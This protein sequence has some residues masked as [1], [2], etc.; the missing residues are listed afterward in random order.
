MVPMNGELVMLGGTDNAGML[1]DHI[2]KYDLQVNHWVPVATALIPEMRTS[3]YLLFN[4]Q[5]LLV[6][7]ETDAVMLQ[8]EVLRSGDAN[9][10]STRSPMNGA[11]P[12]QGHQL[13]NFYGQVLMI[14]GRLN[15]GAPLNVDDKI[16]ASDDGRN[17]TILQNNV[18]FGPRYDFA[19]VNVE[20]DGIEFLYLIGGRRADGTVLNDVWISTTGREWMLHAGTPGFTPRYGM[21]AE[22][23]NGRIYLF[24]GMAGTTVDTAQ[25][26]NQIWEA[27][28]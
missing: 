23:I 19:L 27:M 20:L 6:S 1:I 10:P 21:R 28:P 11:T 18:P 15:D 3:G 8:N 2:I 12:R 14:G 25:P 4:N 7:G 26:S 22:S 24:G 16:Y 5:Y 9:M 17:Y 13:V